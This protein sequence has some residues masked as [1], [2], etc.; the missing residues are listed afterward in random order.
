MSM[1]L[2]FEEEIVGV[3]CVYGPQSG[4]AMAEKQRFY[5]EVACEW[6]LR[7]NVEI[8]LGLVDYSGHVGKPIDG[9]QS[10]QGG[11]GFG[12]RNVARVLRLKA[13]MCGKYLV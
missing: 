1:V 6:N 5:D 3:A 10:I 9:F 12:E 13:I 11:N 4:R 2:M 8:V 7:S